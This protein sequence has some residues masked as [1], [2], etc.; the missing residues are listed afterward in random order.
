MATFFKRRY[1]RDRVPPTEV[2]IG[3]G[4]LALL[5]GIAVAFAVTVRT[6]KNYLFTIDPEYQ[7]DAQSADAS[8]APD[9]FPQPDLAE[10]TLP[11]NVRVFTPVNLYE[12]INGRAPIYLQFG[13]TKLTFGSYQN[14]Q[15]KD[16]YLDVYWYDLATPENAFGIYKTEAGHPEKTLTIG[17][18][19]YAAGAS[20]FFWKGPK[21]V[22]VVSPYEDD[23]H[24]K[25]ARAVAEAIAGAI[26]DDQGQLWAEKLLPAKGRVPDSFNYQSKD[27]LSLSWLRDVFT[28]DYEAAGQTF[29]LFIHRAGSDKIAALYHGKYA[30]FL[31]KY[32][33]VVKKEQLADGWLLVGDSAGMID[34]VI[35]KGRYFGGVYGAG[36]AAKAE[37][38]AR[39]FQKSL[40]ADAGDPNAK[41]PESEPP[42]DESDAGE[43][44]E[45]ES[46]EEG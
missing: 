3:M 24:A 17:R 43:K 16:A 34:V 26:S 8:T 36:D 14:T 30:E 37:A 5:A 7:R 2:L 23:R 39:T 41:L 46:D 33:K 22:Q 32:G 6:D 42:K 11:D 15:N 1:M 27:A 35:T 31:K 21:Y 45:G 44:P 20:V 10:W 28:A 38:T 29:K 40:P 9:E 25:G 19:G 12:K 13:V 4:I 18:E